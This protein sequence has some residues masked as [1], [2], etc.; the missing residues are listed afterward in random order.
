MVCGAAHFRVC[1]DGGADRLFNHLGSFDDSDG[2]TAERRKQYRPDVII[3]DLDSLSDHVQKFYEGMGVDC[4]DLR[5]EQDT[6]D[7]DKCLKH[8]QQKLIQQDSQS[9]DLVVVVGVI[10]FP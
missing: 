9:Q 8:V 10:L 6:T 4:V 1:A 5:T 2:G 7:L 3:G